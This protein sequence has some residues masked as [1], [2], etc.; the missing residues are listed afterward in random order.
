[1]VLAAERKIAAPL[2]DTTLK[3]ATK[4]F[5]LCLSY[6]NLCFLRTWGDLQDHDSDFFKYRGTSWTQLLAITLD[7][8]ILAILLWVPVL[9][10][11]RTGNRKWIR[12]LKWSVMGGLLIPLNSIWHDPYVVRRSGEILHVNLSG[13][14]IGAAGVLLGIVM[15]IGW[16]RFSPRVI[17]VVLTVLTPAFPVAVYRTGLDIHHASSGAFASRKP[18]P[19]LPRRPT[20]SRVLWILFDEWDKTLTFDERPAGLHLPEL[21]RFR[22]ESLSAQSAFAPA[23]F[24]IISVPSLLTGKLYV[25]TRR[26]GPSEMLMTYRRDGAPDL[27]SQQSTVFTEARKSGINAAAAG[28]YL[29]YGRLFDGLSYGFRPTDDEP[30]P[31]LAQHMWE[32]VHAYLVALPLVKRLGIARTTAEVNAIAHE[33]TYHEVAA[34]ARRLASDSSFGMVFLHMSVPHSPFIYDSESGQFSTRRSTT[35]ID[36]LALVDR[37]LGEIRQRMEQSGTWDTT[38]VLLSS[39]HPFRTKLWTVPTQFRGRPV[40]VHQSHTVPFLLKLAGS[41]QAVEYTKPLQTIVTKDLLSA[42][43]NGKVTTPEQAAVWLDTHPPQR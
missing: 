15:L 16:E 17:A 6:A 36:G 12:C 29:P 33:R 26:D 42:V 8:L 25:D 40:E 24:T 2:A 41:R 23:F 38:T 20:Q 19:L 3:S 28:W 30:E 31:T 4:A 18:L 22:A 21:D 34:V 9:L 7:V 27:L 35:Y 43:L 13:S 1:M 5:V 11:V 32:P 10:I 37:T 39:D 14:I